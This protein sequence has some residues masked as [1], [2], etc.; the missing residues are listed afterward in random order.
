MRVDLGYYIQ[1]INQ[2]IQDT[3]AVGEKMNPKF[4]EVKKE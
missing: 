1:M 4:E 2:I 3:E